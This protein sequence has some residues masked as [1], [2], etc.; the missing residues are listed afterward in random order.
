[1]QG[2]I[3]IHALVKR[4]TN[5]ISFQNDNIKDFNPRPRKEGDAEQKMGMAASLDF[6]PRPRKEGDLLSESMTSCV[7]LF[8]STPS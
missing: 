6:N 3:S 7:F 2:Y 1:M 8:Q 5:G 4:A